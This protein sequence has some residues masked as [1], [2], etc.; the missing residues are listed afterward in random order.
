MAK[1]INLSPSAWKDMDM[2]NSKIATP[3]GLDDANDDPND[4]DMFGSKP[5]TLVKSK[6]QPKVIGSKGKLI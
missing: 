5:P 6:S 1:L 2:E 3:P 4:N